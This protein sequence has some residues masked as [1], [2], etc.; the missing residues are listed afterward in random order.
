MLKQLLPDDVALVVAEE[1]DYAAE[2][3]P[4][5]QRYIARAVLKRQREFKAG[6][7]CARRALAVLGQ[8]S[9]F[10]IAKGEMGRPMWPEG[11]VGSI[12]HTH[13]YCAAALALSAKY[14]GIGVDV[15]ENTPLDEALLTMI[16]TAR[17]LQWLEQEPRSKLD[18]GKKIFSMKE[19]VYKALYPV[20]GEFLDF[21]DVYLT[22][23]RATLNVVACVTKPGACHGQKHVVNFVTDDHYIYSSVIVVQRP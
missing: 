3:M 6:R 1:S 14:L 10:A 8:P 4:A 2:V 18:W 5:E 21:S 9:E 16:C 7:S 11:I 12:T 20:Y 19:S 23:D 17:E 15:E 13:G 22:V